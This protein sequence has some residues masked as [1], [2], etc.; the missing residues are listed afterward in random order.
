M[1]E[2]KKRQKTMGIIEAK[3]RSQNKKLQAQYLNIT[4][5]GLGFSN[6]FIRS[7]PQKKGPI[8]HSFLILFHLHYPSVLALAIYKR[9]PSSN[10]SVSV[11]RQKAEEQ[12][13]PWLYLTMSASVCED[14]IIGKKKEERDRELLSLSLCCHSLCLCLLT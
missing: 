8:S 3:A 10:I 2:K 1:K 6:S 13:H 11:K 7:N 12:F 5:D 14:I 4:I 9:G